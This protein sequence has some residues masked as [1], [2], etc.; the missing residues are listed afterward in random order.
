MI[1]SIG[2]CVFILEIYKLYVLL[3][4]A[5]KPKEG[6]LLMSDN[7]SNEHFKYF[8]VLFKK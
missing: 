4:C 5:Y 1:K 8:S 3:T 2:N 7:Y 6:V